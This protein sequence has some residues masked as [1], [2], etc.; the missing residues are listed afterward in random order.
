MEAMITRQAKTPGT[1]T[2]LEPDDGHYFGIQHGGH[3]G[4]Q[5]PVTTTSSRRHSFKSAS[6]SLRSLAITPR[7]D[8]L[9]RSRSRSNSQSISPKSLSMP[10]TPGSQYSRRGGAMTP[11]A[12]DRMNKALRAAEKAQEAADILRLNSRRAQSILKK[13]KLFRT[14]DD[15]EFLSRYLKPYKAFINVSDF[16]LAQLCSIMT[17]EHFEAGKNGMSEGYIKTTVFV[18]GD[19]G[20]DWYIIFSGQVMIQIT[21]TGD[22]K[23]TGDLHRFH[24]IPRFYPDMFKV[25]TLTTG[26]GFGELALINDAPRTATVTAELKTELLRVGKEDYDRYQEIGTKR[27]TG[28]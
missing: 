16:M 7:A 8:F 3:S 19:A 21:K 18:Q 13:S 5:T 23:G 28:S 26:A 25:A 1:F 6:E 24:D 17:L 9:G 4:A 2:D 20:Y 12:R 22:L 14:D 15:T 11:R 27:K 10:G